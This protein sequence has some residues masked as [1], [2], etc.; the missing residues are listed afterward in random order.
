MQAYREEV[1]AGTIIKIKMIYAVTKR[2]KTE[3]LILRQ[4]LR[5]KRRPWASEASHLEARKISPE[6]VNMSID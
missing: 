6:N 1:K 4:V 2:R 3:F 5:Q